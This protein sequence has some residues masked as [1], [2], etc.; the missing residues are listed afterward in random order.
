MEKRYAR[1]SFGDIFKYSFGGIGSNLA[2]FL[3]LSYLTY[4]Y[5]D[6]FGIDTRIVAGLM[7]ISRLIDAFT[8]PL[9]G[10]LADHTH[11]RMGRYRPWIIFGAPGLGITMFLL[12]TAPELSPTLKIVYVYIIYIVYSLVSTVVNIPYH[13]LT[14]VLS[15]D[16]DWLRLRPSL[17]W[18]NTFRISHG[19]VTKNISP[20]HL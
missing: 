18:E 6:I 8:D 19:A 3:V 2:F 9:M 12:F 14:P 1:A 11:S 7:L 5:T 4:F 17:L 10:I 20:D 15:E 16:P 13:S